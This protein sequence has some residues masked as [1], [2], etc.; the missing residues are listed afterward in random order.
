MDTMSR[1][2]PLGLPWHS[3]AGG[4]VDPPSV[5]TAFDAGEQ[6]AASPFLWRP[7]TSVDK[8]A[9]EW[10]EVAPVR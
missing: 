8:L 10:I 9:L 5:V 2:R 7:A 4:G 1:R 6:V 3:A